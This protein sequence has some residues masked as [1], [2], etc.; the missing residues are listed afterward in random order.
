MSLNYRKLL[1]AVDGSIWSRWATEWAIRVAQHCGAEVHALHVY[2]A[3]LHETRFQQME[4]ALPDTYQKEANLARLRRTHAALI[5][6]GLQLIAQSY[7]R[8]AERRARELGVAF[9]PVLREGKHFVEILRYGKESQADLLVLGAK[10]LGGSE[11]VPLGSVAERVLWAA[12]CDL[13]IVRSAFPT[14]SG[15]ILVGVDGSPYSLA[16][17]LQASRWSHCLSLPV[18][19]AAAYDP[20]FHTGVFRTVADVL[21]EDA[22]ARFDFRSQERLHNEI[23]DQGLAHL[24]RS[25]LEQAASVVASPHPP[26][27]LLLE[28]KPFEALVEQALPG[29]VSLIV[30]GRHGAHREGIHPIGFNAV[31]VARYCPVSVLISSAESAPQDLREVASEKTVTWDPQVEE[32][33]QR[34]PS[35]VRGMAKKTIER[36]AKE[37]GYDRV[38]LD[39][40]ERARKHFGM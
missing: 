14:G 20:A 8:E 22:A 33:L 26:E 6:E 25:Y 24:Y 3:R 40:Y 2:A 18:I 16:A 17:A 7:L 1:V 5:G 32:R 15:G 23:I 27:T 30:V 11:R 28:G 31:A 37:Q 34:I 38:T 4:P 29:R 19:L 35:F 12:E 10:G 39:V 21:P 36:F 13:L 9:T